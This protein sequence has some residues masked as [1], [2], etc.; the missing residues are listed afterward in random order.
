M[1][2]IIFAWGMKRLIFIFTVL[3]FSNTLVAQDELGQS[4]RVYH[5]TL[6]LGVSNKVGGHYIDSYVVHL[7]K[8]Q[9]LQVQIE[10]KTEQSKVY[11]DV[12]L[13]GTE[14]RFGRDSSENSWSGVA[15]ESGDY[16]IRLIAYPVAEYR[17]LVYSTPAR[18]P[19]IKTVFEHS[20]NA[21]Q[22]SAYSYGRR[23]RG[24]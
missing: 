8:G 5:A 6:P 15:P 16:E 7:K 14:T 22:R 1:T 4:K 17:L 20:V 23:R 21:R 2:N 11:F 10:N 12:V 13:A 24:K 9:E 19:E 3:L 18:E